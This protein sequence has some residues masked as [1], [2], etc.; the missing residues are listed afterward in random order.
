MNDAQINDLMNAAARGDTAAVIGLLA[1]G[2]DVN[3]SDD[4]GMTALMHAVKA[5]HAE[6]TRTLLY[7]G[8]DAKAKGR[9]LGYEPIVFAVKAGDPVL[10]E[11]LLASAEFRA[12][13]AK[14]ALGVARLLGNER[15]IELLKACQ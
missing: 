7:R 11:L 1:G 5:G 10:V 9:F 15:V 3:A 2:V 13:D 8:A 14:F 4:R 12:Q 6:T